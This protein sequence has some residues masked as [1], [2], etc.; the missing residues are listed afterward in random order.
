MVITSPEDGV[1]KERISI[2]FEDL[3]KDN[4]ELHAILEE[5]E[6]MRWNI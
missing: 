2:I 6:Y 4:D 3:R 1:T 5:T